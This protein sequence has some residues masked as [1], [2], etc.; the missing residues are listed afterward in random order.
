MK[1]CLGMVRVRLP[2][3]LAV[4]PAMVALLAVFGSTAQAVILYRETFGTETT[5]G[6]TAT[7]GYDWAVHVNNAAATCLDQ[8]AN[9]TNVV[10]VNRNANASKP[11]TTDTVGQVNAG[12]VIGN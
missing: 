11:G 1:M 3:R 9:T 10:S 4:L 2:W 8:S 12:P 5:G 7:Q 6:Q